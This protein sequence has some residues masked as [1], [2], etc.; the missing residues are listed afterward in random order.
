MSLIPFI[1][2]A[3]VRTEPSFGLALASSRPFVGD[4][5]NAIEHTTDEM[6]QTRHTIIRHLKKNARGQMCE[7]KPYIPSAMNEPP[8]PHG[9]TVFAALVTYPNNC[10]A[11]YIHPSLGEAVNWLRSAYPTVK[12][13]GNRVQVD[14]C[15]PNNRR[16]LQ[17][18]ECIT[19]GSSSESHG[20]C[21]WVDAKKRAESQEAINAP[22]AAAYLAEQLDAGVKLPLG[23]CFRCGMKQTEVRKD[24]IWVCG[25]MKQWACDTCKYGRNGPKIPSKS[26]GGCEWCCAKV[27][28]FQGGVYDCPACKE[29]KA[30]PY[31]V[32][33]TTVPTEAPSATTLKPAAKVD[34][35]QSALMFTKEEVLAPRDVSAITDLPHI[36]AVKTRL[37]EVV[38]KRVADREAA[39][40][41]ALAERDA[42]VNAAVSQIVTEAEEPLIQNGS[43]AI[44]EANLYRML[45]VT[46]M[47]IGDALVITHMVKTVLP[48]VD[49]NF[50]EGK[51]LITLK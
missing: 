10:I 32:E 33:R 26:F 16:N 31:S 8:K 43:Y 30:G 2:F 36:R 13:I 21:T 12:M 17:I 28:P 24:G 22:Q 6:A 29:A 15:D 3:I 11:L 19:N 23:M 46:K 40:A 35:S 39:K 5:F 51:M 50:G 1:M 14:T 42:R 25:E 41:T 9:A 38:A 45:G 4:S 20:W 49:V 18:W 44:P 27:I 34:T 37:A 48:M 7:E 47:T